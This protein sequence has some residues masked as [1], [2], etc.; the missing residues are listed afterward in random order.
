MIGVLVT[1]SLPLLP[2]TIAVCNQ[3]HPHILILLKSCPLAHVLNDGQTY[4]EMAVANGMS[5]FTGLCDND[6]PQSARRINRW[7]P[8]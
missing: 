7:L 2:G 1:S 8:Y 5:Y 3:I 6:P 4:C